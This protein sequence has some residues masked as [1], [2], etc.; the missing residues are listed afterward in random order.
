MGENSKIQWTHH[1]FNPWRGCAKV[2]PGCDHCYAEATSK[3]NPKVLGIWGTDGTRVIASD[4][5]WREPRRWNLEAVAAGERRRV[6][7]ASL[8][9]VGEDR[10]DLVEPRERLSRLILETA[11]LDWLLLTKRIENMA[12]LFPREVL[13]RS[14]VGTTVEDQQRADERI[15]RL[16]QTPAAVRFI[17][18]EPLIESVS[19]HPPT[20]SA[21][22]LLWPF[23]YTGKFDEAAA[24]C[25][26]PPP[27][28][29]AD[30][31]PK[32]DWVIVGGES[33]PGARP[34]DVAFAR[35]I[36]RQCKDAGVPV[37]VKQLGADPFEPYSDGTRFAD[38]RL[39]DRKGGNLV[40][41]PDDLQVRQFPEVHA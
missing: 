8:A 28:R 32:I 22:R 24:E 12:R 37:F 10:L 11:H 38:V 20:D 13:E 16:C 39:E 31:F 33:G 2:S 40:E 29:R 27:V 36:V 19:L 6:F 25:A 3:R 5:M 7:C 30:L 9:D 21:Y 41:W 26:P 14:W 4:A 15:K 23:Y 17:S 35:S 18:A 34:F 1:T